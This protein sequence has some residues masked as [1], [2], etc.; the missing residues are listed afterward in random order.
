MG[1]YYLA[2]YTVY[3]PP[4]RMG[5]TQGYFS[6]GAG[7]RYVYRSER[8]H[9]AAAGEDALALFFSR[10]WLISSSMTPLATCTVGRHD[11]EDSLLRATVLLTHLRLERENWSKK[12]TTINTWYAVATQASPGC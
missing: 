8:H 1:L 11:V 2:S 4:K 7:T 9:R 6:N 12:V 3:N 5:L 10:P